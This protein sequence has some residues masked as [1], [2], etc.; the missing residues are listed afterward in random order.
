MVR[1]NDWSF[2]TE[3]LRQRLINPISSRWEYLAGSPQSKKEADLWNMTNAIL[4]EYVWEPYPGKITLLAT[5]QRQ[6]DQMLKYMID[7]WTPLAKGGLDVFVV[8]GNHG[9][10]FYEPEV[11]HL[12]GQLKQCLDEA[13]K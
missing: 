1:G 5:K 2:V 9:A 13:N 8:S 12:A 6:E 7:D 3:V 10:I 4:D 11:E